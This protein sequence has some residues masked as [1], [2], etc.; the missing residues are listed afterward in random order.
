[1]GPD[2]LLSS[3]LARQ[4]YH[5]AAA[6][7]PIFDFHSHLSAAAIAS[8]DSFENLSHLMLT[9]DHHKWRL[10]MTDGV[11]EELIRGNADDW[12]KFLAYA[13]VLQGAI[14]HPLYHWTHL[15]LQRIFDIHEPLSEN[16]AKRVWDICNERLKS[17]EYSAQGLLS[18][19]RVRTVYT[20]EDPLDELK[21]HQRLRSNPSVRIRLRPTFCPD[22][23]LSPDESGFADY[24]GKLAGMAGLSI[25]S[26]PDLMAALER[27][28]D[29]FHAQGCRTADHGL[30]LVP[31]MRLNEERAEKAFQA[32][33]QG[34]PLSAKQLHSYQALMYVS[35]GLQYA[36]RNWV[37]QYHIGS[38]GGNNQ[39]MY[40]LYGDDAGFDAASDAPLAQGLARLLDAQDRSMSLPK[41]VLYGINPGYHDVIASLMDSFQQP[42]VRSKMQLGPPWRFHNHAGGLRRYL[43]SL[44]SH[45]LLSRSIGMTADSRCFASFS[46]HEYF[47]RVLCQL[48]AEWVSAGEYP[49][50]VT[51]LKTMV[52]N[53]AYHNA[54]AYFA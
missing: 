49:E 46:R 18:L 44:A 32:A 39:R 21:A 11:D 41:T 27:R 29:F 22:R 7:M 8:N 36:K 34:Q 26:L 45:S 24:I 25:R 3:H 4:L 9:G 23:V 43:R 48:V 40:A 16:T 1:M 54:V 42:H 14:G 38:L 28:M 53:I 20:A 50:D 13:R 35:L 31:R 30:V 10:L 47:R 12:D 6:E 17:P 52:R 5:E 2:F 51:Y 15:E 33:L 19:F 37:Q